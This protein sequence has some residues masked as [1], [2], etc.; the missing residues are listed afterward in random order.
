MQGFARVANRNTFRQIQARG[1]N[2]LWDATTLC[3]PYLQRAP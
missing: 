3:I 1:I 2:S